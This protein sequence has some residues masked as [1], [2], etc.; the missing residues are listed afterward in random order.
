MTMRIKPN[1][2]GFNAEASVHGS[3]QRYTQAPETARIALRSLVVA[4]MLFRRPLGDCIPGC[5]CV[6]PINCPCCEVWGGF[7]GSKI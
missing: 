2:P 6:S 1:V 7:G 4:Q 3:T 5:I